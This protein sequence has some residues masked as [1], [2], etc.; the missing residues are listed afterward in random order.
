MDDVE[1]DGC[2]T[3]VADSREDVGTAS[4]GLIC[5][6]MASTVLQLSALQHNISLSIPKFFT[7]PVQY[8]KEKK[9]SLLHP[10]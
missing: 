1:E 9:K 6:M 8:A 7:S 2:E 10:W 4:V 3:I 5:E